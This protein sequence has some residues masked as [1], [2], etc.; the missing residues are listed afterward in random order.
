MARTGALGSVP[1]GLHGHQIFS[2]SSSSV[3]GTVGG[4]SE[5][6]DLH[7]LVAQLL[8]LELEGAFRTIVGFI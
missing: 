4:E 3:G 2:S 8:G 1:H 5:S 6:W 7:G